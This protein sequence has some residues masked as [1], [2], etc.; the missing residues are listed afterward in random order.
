MK[1]SE[2][3]TF[4]Y[5]IS[6]FQRRRGDFPELSNVNLLA[7]EI[8]TEPGVTL[9]SRPGLETTDITMG[10]G[11][12]KELFQID[13]VLSNGLFGVSGTKLYNGA[14]ELGTVTGT[15]N[16]SFAG[17]EDFVFVTAGQSIHS[18][19]SSTFATLTFPDDADV[20]KIAVGAS[21]LIALRKDTGKFYWSGILNTT[22][23]ALNFATA[24]N[25]PDK[26]IDLIYLADR[27]ILFGSETVEF[28]PA[29]GDSDLP[30]APLSGATWQV[31]C[32]AVG[33]AQH[34]NRG[35]AWIT[36]YNEVCVNSPENIVSDPELQIQISNS[37][38]VEMFTFYVDDNEYLAIRLDDKTWVYGAR[39]QVWSIFESYDKDNWVCQCFENGYF[40]SDQNGTLLQ[41]SAEAYEDLEGPIERRFEGWVSLMG[42]PLQIGNIQLR[43]NPGTTPFLTG[44]YLNPTVELRT[45]RDG[46]KTW[47]K[48][49]SRSLGTQGNYRA[50]TVWSSMG[51]FGYPGV[52]VQVRCSDPVP[53]RVSNLTY[54]EPLGG[55]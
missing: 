27:L 20:S 30:Y 22:I 48:W 38:S 36:N 10:S 15:G 13:G 2:P 51:Q 21:R 6:E 31:G 11:P 23:D 42:Q 18:W 47:Q 8:P 45:S 33:L 37:S 55:I 14:T 5:G 52:L 46:G 9:Q 24:E 19:D 34:F 50:K 16:I 17:Y 32:K 26:L 44:D 54:N 29:T 28:W 43:T 49:K 40:G 1:N 12:V 4:I 3:G 53:F 41:F 25:S 39:T 35:F 7:E